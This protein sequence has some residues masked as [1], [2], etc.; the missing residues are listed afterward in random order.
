MKL[1]IFRENPLINLRRFSKILENINYYKQNDN[2]WLETIINESL[3]VE[4]GKEINHIK[5]NMTYEKPSDSDI[6]NSKIIYENLKHLSDSQ[7]SDERLWSSLTHNIFW[8]YMQYRWPL[9]ASETKLEV[10][11]RSHYFFSN[12]SRGKY[13]NGISRLW[14]FARLTYD[15]NRKNPY[16]ILEYFKNGFSG[17]LYPLFAGHNYANNSLVFK[18][19][20][21]GIFDY[22]KKN[23][24]IKRSLFSKLTKSIDLLGGDLQLDFL[25]ENKILRSYV[26]NQ[27]ESLSKE[28]NNK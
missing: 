23:G 27:L 24:K 7:A 14:W 6:E 16:E 18:E 11:V 28:F 25:A 15:E 1:K 3:F 13:F 17:K 9:S 2:T 5:L 20:I 12:R 19:F 10:Y 8:D 21:N 22:E 26:L 4:F